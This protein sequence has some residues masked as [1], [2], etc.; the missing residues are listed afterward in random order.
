MSTD[1]YGYCPT[2]KLAHYVGYRWGGAGWSWGYGRNDAE[3]QQAAGQFV[4]DHFRCQ[5]TGVSILDCHS[6]D[7]LEGRDADIRHADSVELK[8]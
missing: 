7:A 4:L 6:M 3:G 8:K 5:D 1:F 2:C